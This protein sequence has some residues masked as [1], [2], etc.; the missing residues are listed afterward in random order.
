MNLIA[1][2][3]PRL[4]GREEATQPLGS[5]LVNPKLFKRQHIFGQDIQH[6][7]DDTG[8]GA[9]A[10]RQ[11]DTCRC[12]CST[13]TEDN[14]SDCSTGRATA[15]RSRLAVLKKDAITK[16]LLLIARKAAAAAA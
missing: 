13:R 6:S 4:P 5:V 2:P 14:W 8:G 1:A 12:P 7:R 15:G 9:L 3:F 16:G 10:W 11:G